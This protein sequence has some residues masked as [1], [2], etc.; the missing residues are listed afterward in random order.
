VGSPA[1][2]CF[3]RRSNSTSRSFLALGAGVHP[4]KRT[5]ARSGRWR[6]A[7]GLQALHAAFA[8]ADSLSARGTTDWQVAT[9]EL[10]E[11]SKPTRRRSR[12]AVTSIGRFDPQRSFDGL[13][14]EESEPISLPVAFRFSIPVGADDCGRG[15]CVELVLPIPSWVGFVPVR[16]PLGL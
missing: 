12:L 5:R 9:S 16:V 15:L 2:L 3:L 11:L 8:L 1:N 10:A 6:D 7:R 14:V 13:W 4:A